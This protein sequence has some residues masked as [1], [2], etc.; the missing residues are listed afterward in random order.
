MVD[1]A[2]IGRRV[3]ARLQTATACF[4]MP[5]AQAE[6]YVIRDYLTP[7]ECAGLIA[8]I[9]ANRYP[10]GVL[11]DVPDPGHRTSESAN[12]DP[13]DPVV[14]VAEAKI[15]VLLG[16]QPEHGETV[17]GQRYAPGQE[18]KPHHDFFHTSQNYYR[19]EQS[20]GG[21]RTWTAMAFLNQPEAGGETC[22]PEIG[23]K[24]TPRPGNLL[25]WNNMDEAGEPNHRTLHQGMPVIAGVKYII[26]KW[27]RERPWG[28][29]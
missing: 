10:S 1:R 21:Q 14:A 2:E 16:I 11:S 4:R 22:F 25:V 18:F 3:R 17:Q 29:G 23:V 26:T 7:T 9:D 12:L 13:Y 28:R 6:L 8:R 15:N 5:V 27:Y 19:I 24:I 20:Q